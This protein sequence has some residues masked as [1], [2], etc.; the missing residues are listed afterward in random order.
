ME[1]TAKAQFSIKDNK[2]YIFHLLDVA[3]DPSW[4]DV[5]TVEEHRAPCGTLL[6][7]V[8]HREKTFSER[9]AELRK[10]IANDGVDVTSF[11]G[12]YLPKGLK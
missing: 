5:K 2:G 3:S 7:V 4:D 9:K 6:S 10:Q 12:T 8:N 11:G 1:Q